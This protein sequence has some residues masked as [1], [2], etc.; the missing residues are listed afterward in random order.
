MAAKEKGFFFFFSLSLLFFLFLFF[1]LS[2]LSHIWCVGRTTNL[3]Y[4]CAEVKATPRRRLTSIRWAATGEGLR[5]FASR[6]HF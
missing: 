2:F 4:G 3:K 5:R 1:S 6:S